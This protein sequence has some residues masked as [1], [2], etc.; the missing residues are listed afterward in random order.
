MVLGSFLICVM[1]VV[2]AVSAIGSRQAD[3]FDV[4][5]EKPIESVVKRPEIEV[6]EQKSQEISESVN[7]GRG[8][9]QPTSSQVRTAAADR[10]TPGRG[11]GPVYGELIS[12]PSIGLQAG[13]VGVGLDA[14]GAVGVPA[15]QVGWYNGSSRPGQAGASFLDGHTPGV[16]GGLRNVAAGATVNVVMDGQTYSYRVVRTETTL[17]EQVDMLAI[18]TYGGGQDTLVMMTCAGSPIGNTY[19]HRLTVYAVRI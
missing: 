16:F 7:W 18:L 4:F 3:F 15:A 9:S 8:Y 11:S 6:F 10:G 19:S 14:S 2:S 5:G 17:L 12:I 13:L 1:G